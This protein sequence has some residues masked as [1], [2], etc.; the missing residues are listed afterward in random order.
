ALALR[1]S[2]EEERARQAAAA[3]Q[4]G[5]GQGSEAAAAT[6]AASAP[7]GEVEAMDE[8]D[9]LQQALALSMQTEEGGD[10][11]G[12]AVQ[13][14]PMAGLTQ[15]VTPRAPM[16]GGVAMQ[17]EEDELEDPELALALQMSM[18]EEQ[19]REKKADE[20]SK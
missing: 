2:M 9:L 18:A 1:V 15:G 14:T 8:D 7:A 5:D 16:R 11:A 3:S 13:P 12:G 20:E 4:A 17:G 19:P 10:G 6:P